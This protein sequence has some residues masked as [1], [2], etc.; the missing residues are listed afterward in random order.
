MM[1]IEWMRRHLG[2][3]YNI[4][5]LSFKDSNP[6]HMD[7]TFTFLRPGLIL[8]N[9]DRPCKQADFF[10]KKGWKII[11]APPPALSDSHRLYISTKW[12]AMNILMIDENRVLCDP[13]EKPLIKVNR[14][15]KNVFN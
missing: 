4:H 3:K 12:I 6:M 5:V 10:E 11:K 15:F 13:D 14:Y 8:S 9:P 2:D 1:G 7:A